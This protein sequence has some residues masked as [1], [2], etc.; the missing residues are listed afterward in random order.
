[1]TTNILF[2]S[3]FY[4]PHCN[5]PSKRAME[6]TKRLVNYGFKFFILSGR[7][8]TRPIDYK[9][10]KD[11][12]TENV[13]NY[14][15]VHL[16][17]MFNI[18][19]KN[20]LKRI[21]LKLDFFK[22]GFF[23]S[24][25]PFAFINATKIIAKNEI[26]FIYTTGPP[27]FALFLGYLLKKVYKLP[28]IIEFRD[29]W[30]HSPYKKEEKFTKKAYMKFRNIEKKIIDSADLIFVIS[31]ALIKF[32][33]R[34]FPKKTKGKDIVSFPSGINLSNIPRKLSNKNQNREINFTFLGTLY[35]L[36]DPK[37]L[38]IILDLVNSKIDLN[39]ISLKINIFGDYDRKYLSSLLK[40]YGLS[41]FFYLGKYLSHEECLEEIQSSTLPLH[42]GENIDYPT[43]SFKVWEYLSMNKKVLYFGRDDSYTTQFLRN[44]ELGYI[45]PINDYQLGAEKFIE[46]IQNIKNNNLNLSV[47]DQKL[48]QFGWEK[49][50]KSFSSAVKNL[51]RN[52]T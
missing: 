42:I 46:L 24:W 11:I 50:I 40:R 16:T 34:K 33:R 29:P 1:M 7:I 19:Q 5:T 36:R 10:L 13:K 45:I 2:L 43:I 41:D 3:F 27:F 9:L 31:D 4:P 49:I 20:I 47:G 44:N 22:P 21:S 51:K 23:L 30:M 39:S 14:R 18:L 48:K 17:H 25:T 32:L 37:H 28:L 38:V 6:I 12:E 15:V 52:K 35:G 8:L 26:D